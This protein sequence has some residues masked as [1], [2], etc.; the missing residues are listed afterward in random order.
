MNVEFNG[1][2]RVFSSENGLRF[3]GSLETIR[4]KYFLFGNTFKIERGS[5]VFDNV[6][7]IDPKLDLLVSADI[8]TGYSP[9]ERKEM[10]KTY[11]ERVE[12]SI[13]GTLSAPEVTPSPDSPYSKE[14]I[15][16]LLAFHQ[17]F[18]TADTLK[19][20]S[21]FQDEI[22]KNL[23][24]AYGTRLLENIA[25]SSL[26]VETFEIQPAWAGKFSLWDTR[27]TIGKYI[28]DKVY[29]KYS[30]RLSRSRGEEAG[31]EYRLKRYLFLEGFRDWE[32]KV[33]LG[34]NLHWEY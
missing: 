17:R 30:R 19:M 7:R 27:I 22:L 28:S 1:E 25:T 12:F 21:V 24:E 34:L 2:V 31:L 23:G 6:E 11:A 13:K 32:G 5:F 26:G 29:F 14:E 4:G 9:A 18:F 8:A 16:E 10:T 15:L 20:G 3:L 33:Y